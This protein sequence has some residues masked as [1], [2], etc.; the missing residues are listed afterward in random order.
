MFKK[1]FTVS[2]SSLKLLKTGER[3][4]ITKL[5]AT[6]SHTLRQFKE[7]GL[8]PGASLKLEQRFPRFVVRVGENRVVLDD[9]A[10]RSIYVRL[11]ESA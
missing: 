3:G 7:M 8:K 1:S 9:L 2:G 6:D 5:T 4:V 11:K 10:K